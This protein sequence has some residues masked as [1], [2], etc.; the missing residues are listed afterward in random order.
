MKRYSAAGTE[1]VV[2]ESATDNWSIIAAANKDYYWLHLDDC[3]SAHI[4]I[5]IDVEPTREEIAFAAQLVRTATP[6]APPRAGIVWTQVS[7][8]RRGSKPGEVYFKNAT[9]AVREP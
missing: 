7:N 1:F 2:G 8:L 9:L 3:P 5:E 4:I 6:R